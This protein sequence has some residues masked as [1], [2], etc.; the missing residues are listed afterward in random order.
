MIFII[1]KCP[2]T[3]EKAQDV[4]NNNSCNFIC[5]SKANKTEFTLI[6]N[7][8]VVPPTKNVDILHFTPTKIKDVNLF[9]ESIYEKKLNV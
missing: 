7:C 8:T 6:K 5:S 9:N 4:E 2:K 1:T 3:Q